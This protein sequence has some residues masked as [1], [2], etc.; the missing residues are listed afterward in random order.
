MYV[1]LAQRTKRL[2]TH[3][4][5]ASRPIKDPRPELRPLTGLRG[6]AATIVALA[7]FRPSLPYGIEALFMWQNAAVDLF[8]CLSGFTLCYVYSRDRFQFAD[9]LTARIA[10]TYPLY[11]LTLITAGVCAWPIITD[12]ITYPLKAA[13]SDFLLQV[14]MLNS[15]PIIGSGVHWNFP[16]WSISVEW[17]C[18]ILLF[19]LLLL[20]TAPRSTPIR[21]LCLVLLSAASYSLFMHYFDE[22]INTPEIYVAKSQWSYWVNLLRSIF[23]FTAGWISFASFEKRDGLHA[24]CTRYS[25]AIWLGFFTILVLRYCGLVDSQALVFL[26]PFVVLAATDSA[27]ATSRLLGTRALHFLGTISYSIYMVHTSV[28]ILFIRGF[29]APDDWPMSIYVLLVVTTFAI[30]IGTHLVIEMPARNAIRDLRR[31]RL[32]KQ[33]QVSH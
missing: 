3:Q 27:S 25:T 4:I 26:F 7:H 29:L 8:F 12:S 1:D 31:R 6:I 10:R 33:L 2:E 22:H 5:E 19:P 9:Y 18:Y 28:F 15:W 20:Q 32:E 17:F 13:F 16:A 21:L 24:F 30:A 14:F 23:G 11:F